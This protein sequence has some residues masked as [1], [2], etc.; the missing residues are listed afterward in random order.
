MSLLDGSAIV[1]CGLDE[2]DSYKYSWSHLQFHPLQAEV[3]DQAAYRVTALDCDG[4]HFST[5]QH[6]VGQKPPGRWGLRF[7][8]VCSI[9]P[10][11]VSQHGI[12]AP[13]MASIILSDAVVIFLPLLCM[14][15]SCANKGWR[16]SHWL[17]FR[18]GHF[19]VDRPIWG[20]GTLLWEKE[21]DASSFEDLPC[22]LVWELS[23]GVWRSSLNW[24]LRVLLREAKKEGRWAAD[25]ESGSW[26]GGG[27]ITKF[28]LLWNVSKRGTVWGFFEG[29][30]EYW[31]MDQGWKEA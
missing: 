15:N 7:C 11:H 29:V 14:N 28:Q 2:F 25:G 8:L 18:E 30:R 6:H 27:C 20:W 21:Y 3:F 5:W 4:Y 24:E 23:G 31:Q 10:P 26:F 16:V 22:W 17:E 12:N 9:M 19:D 13:S 1:R